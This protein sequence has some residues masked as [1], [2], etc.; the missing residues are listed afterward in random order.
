[1][2]HVDIKSAPAEETKHDFVV[3]TT[4]NAL[5]MTLGSTYCKERLLI[6]RRDC[7]HK[8]MVCYHLFEYYLTQQHQ[9]TLQFRTVVLG[10]IHK[11][12]FCISH[13]LFLQM[14]LC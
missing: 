6:N 2:I 10:K 14:L 11:I 1:M 8:F 12:Y 9:F 7:W 13:I 3:L 5:S 4:L